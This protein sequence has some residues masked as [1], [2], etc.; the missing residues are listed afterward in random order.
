MS[1]MV[2]INS[3]T[4]KGRRLLAV[5]GPLSILRVL[6]S[7]TRVGTASSVALLKIPEAPL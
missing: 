5:A 7:E 4:T 6:H 2:K 1:S 3:S